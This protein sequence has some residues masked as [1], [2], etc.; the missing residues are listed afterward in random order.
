MKI[1]KNDLF[2]FDF[3]TVHKLQLKQTGRLELPE[4]QKRTREQ[5]KITLLLID[6][7]HKVKQTRK[8]FS[9]NVLEV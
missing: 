4:P 1:F 3:M 8:V 6:G 9:L 2:I 5:M 7:Y